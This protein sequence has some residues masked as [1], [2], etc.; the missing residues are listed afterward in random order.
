GAVVTDN[1][2]IADRVRT[3]RVHGMGQQYVHDK[4]SQNF[5]MSEMEAAWLRL[6]LAELDDDLSRRRAIVSAY[7]DAAPQLQWQA[8]NARHAYHLAVFRSPARTS[9]RAALEQKGVATAVHY[10]LAITQQPAYRDL[11]HAPCPQAEAWA[12]ECISVPCFPEM[13]DVEVELVCTALGAC[14]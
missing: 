6:A 9:T 10:P 2:E 8:D 11:I 4:I 13:T 1:R 14:E 5:R 7:R 12:R 3:L